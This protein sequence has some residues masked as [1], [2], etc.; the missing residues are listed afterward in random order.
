[1]PILINYLESNYIQKS[2]LLKASDA[3]LTPFRKAFNGRDVNIVFNEKGIAEIQDVTDKVSTVKKILWA[4][5]AISIAPFAA[6]AAFF[7]LFTHPSIGSLENPFEIG[8]S[9][10]PFNIEEAAASLESIRAAKL[11]GNVKVFLSLS[12][13]QQNLSK[14]EAADSIITVIKPWRAEGCSVRVYD[15]AIKFAILECHT[16][17]S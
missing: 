12:P 5:L 11:F 15:A 8:N 17:L 3:F 10:V 7:K 1:M 16:F 4:I 6:I 2:P 13:Q 14:V 9:E